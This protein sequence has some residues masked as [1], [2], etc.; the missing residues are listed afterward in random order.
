MVMDTCSPLKLIFTCS[1]VCLFVFLHSCTDD[2]NTNNKTHTPM[3]TVLAQFHQSIRYCARFFGR[4]FLKRWNKGGK[5]ANISALVVVR[6]MNSHAATEAEMRSKAN[7]CIW[8]EYPPPHVFFLGYY[9]RKDG[10][11]CFSRT[12]RRRLPLALFLQTLF[13]ILT[14]ALSTNTVASTLD[15]GSCLSF[16]LPLLFSSCLGSGFSGFPRI[17]VST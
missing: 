4:R 9:R 11:C 10:K 16:R 17:Q 2:L 15:H 5:V 13:C 12:V 1:Q 3:G 14:Q 6:S 7:S 8:Q